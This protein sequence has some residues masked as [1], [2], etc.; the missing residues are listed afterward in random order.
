VSAEQIWVPYSAFPVHQPFHVDKAREVWAFGAF[1][2][3]KTIA[4]AGDAIELGV[5]QYGSRIMMSRLTIASLRDTLEAE[6][7]NLLTSNGGDETATTLWE[8][9]EARKANNHYETIVF[10]NGSVY[11][12]LGLD[13]WKKRMGFSVAGFYVD[14]AS[15]VPLETYS[16]ISQSRVRQ[17]QITPEAR[18]LG[19]VERPPEQWERRIRGAQNPAGHDWAWERFVNITDAERKRLMDKGI[20]R[21]YHRSTAMDNPTLYNSDGTPNEFLTGM[22]DMPEQWVKRYVLCQFDEFAGSILDFSRSQHVVPAFQPPRHWKRAMGLDWGLRAPT[23]CGWWAQDPED[24][25]WYKYREWMSHDPGPDVQRA[26]PD[27][28]IPPTEVARIIGGLEAGE[29]IHLRA[30]D[31]DIRKRHPAGDVVRSTE[32]WFQQ[33]GIHFQLG[34]KDHSVRIA[35]QIE[36][37]HTGR[38]KIMDN[39]PISIRQYESYRWETAVPGRPGREK[40][41]RSKPRTVDDHLLDADQYLFS[42]WYT[43]RKPR[44]FVDETPKT[45]EEAHLEMVHNRIEEKVQKAIAKKRRGN[46]HKGFGP[47]L[48]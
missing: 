37:L 31:P 10:P 47:A 24:G 42:L 30:A 9:C 36:M 43:G 41:V 29:T 12:F 48:K 5:K 4:L 39:C 17:Q 2:S 18:S 11:K 28:V 34:A 3:G 32:Y 45:V 19:Y 44:R 7:I 14:E 8:L 15:E 40:E 23:A 21:S 26:D 22:L 13:D 6:F 33:L 1:A 46:R 35:A 20:G 27:R 25:T 16:Q 38:A